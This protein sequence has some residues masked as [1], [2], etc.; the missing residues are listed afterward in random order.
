MGL[1]G[2]FTQ[3]FFKP[4][5]S[6][7]TLKRRFCPFTLSLRNTKVSYDCHG[8]INM[9]EIMTATINPNYLKIM[10]LKLQLKKYFQWKS[11]VAQEKN[12]QQRVIT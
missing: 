7:S 11:K 1:Y 6:T 4:L 5:Y 10:L 8:E 12:D 3:S 9:V 2:N